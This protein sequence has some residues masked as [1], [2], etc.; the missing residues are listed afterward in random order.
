MLCHD[1]YISLYHNNLYK[2]LNICKKLQICVY[3]VSNLSF[4]NIL[5][6]SKEYDKA[7]ARV[8]LY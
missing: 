1:P 8:G 6:A 7:R 5:R 4:L 3:F 2:R